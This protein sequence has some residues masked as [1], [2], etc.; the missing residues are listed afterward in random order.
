MNKEKICCICGKKFIGHGHDPFPVK[1]GAGEVC[2]DECEYEVVL[3]R[4]QVMLADGNTEGPRG[5]Q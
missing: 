3:P 1:K 5:I 4:R 2:C